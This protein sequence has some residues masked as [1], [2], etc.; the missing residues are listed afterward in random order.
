[1]SGPTVLPKTDV[2]LLFV[3]AVFYFV[4]FLPFAFGKSQKFGG[5]GGGRLKT[6]W[7]QAF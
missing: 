5:E 4:V 1:M 3:V 7:K 2:G 6:N